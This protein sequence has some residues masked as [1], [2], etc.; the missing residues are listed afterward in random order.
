M[1]N[2]LVIR[3]LAGRQ[4]RCAANTAVRARVRRHSR[5]LRAMATPEYLT[6]SQGK[7]P[8]IPG[9]SQAVGVARTA[10]IGIVSTGVIQAA[11][12]AT[13]F[14]IPRQALLS[15]DGGYTGAAVG[16]GCLVVQHSYQGPAFISLQKG[17]AMEGQYYCGLHGWVSLDH[18]PCTED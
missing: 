8:G 10:V 3:G 18:F 2:E 16:A 14:R 4:P 13:H 15:R 17:S 5:H 6:T 1:R 12:P 7:G 11:T 9:G